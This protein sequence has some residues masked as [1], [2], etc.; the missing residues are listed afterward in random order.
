MADAKTSAL[1]AVTTPA[2]TFEIPG[3]EAGTSKKLTL[4]QIDVYTS[5]I[6]NGGLADQTG[7]ASDT[8]ITS[9]GLTVPPSRLQAG[10]WYRYV[11]EIEK[12]NA[13]TAVPVFTLRMGTGGATSDAA[14]CTFTFG[15][16]GTAAIDRGRFEILANFTSVGASTSAVVRGTLI[17]IH[18]NSNTGFV[19]AGGAFQ[20]PIKVTSSGFDST[21]VTKIG[22]SANGGTSASWTLTTGQ[23][24]IQNLAS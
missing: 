2:G 6:S 10:T 4:S 14:I 15:S 12:T 8:Y 5:P 1:T 13:G 17:L 24:E 16:A 19:S 21:T 11:A 7:F 18:Q 23:A 20:A 22:L 9:S 3:N